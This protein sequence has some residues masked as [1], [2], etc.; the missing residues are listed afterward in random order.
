MYDKEQLLCI[1]LTLCQ[2]HSS[3]NPF[4]LLAGAK[5]L[6]RKSIS[7]KMSLS[8]SFSFKIIFMVFYLFAGSTKIGA[9]T[10]FSPLPV[11]IL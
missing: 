2:P 10:I 5:I 6:L 11:A 1:R 3:L 4:F 7:I 8:T 9:I